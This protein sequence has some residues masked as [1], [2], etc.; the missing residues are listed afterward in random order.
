MKTLSS[1]KWIYSLRNKNTLKQNRIY[2]F[3]DYFNPSKWEVLRIT[4]KRKIYQLHL[5]RTYT[6]TD[7][8]WTSRKKKIIGIVWCHLVEKSHR[9]TIWNLSRFF[10]VTKNETQQYQLHAEKAS[11]STD[12]VETPYFR[13]I[14][15][16]RI[17][18]QQTILI[19]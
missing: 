15:M 17:P 6:Y 16:S 11:Y 8:R 12:Q 7:F 13:I 1:Y 19:S 18:I 5:T 2:R 4:W 14:Y 9:T 10:A 3:T